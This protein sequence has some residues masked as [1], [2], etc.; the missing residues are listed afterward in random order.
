MQS[1]YGLTEDQVAG[2]FRFHIL[3]LIIKVKLKIVEI[4]FSIDHSLV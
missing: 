3:I 1:E 4:V 2:K